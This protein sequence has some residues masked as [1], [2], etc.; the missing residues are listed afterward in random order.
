MAEN[1][2]L[3]IVKT[4]YDLQWFGQIESTHEELSQGISAI[5]SIDETCFK[6]SD[7]TV[8]KPFECLWILYVWTSGKSIVQTHIIW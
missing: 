5:F 3:Q 6:N 4:I 7:K 1:L 8:P 2:K